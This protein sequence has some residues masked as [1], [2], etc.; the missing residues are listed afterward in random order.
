[1]PLGQYTLW[2]PC[3]YVEYE[4]PHFTRAQL[5][6]AGSLRD[7]KLDRLKALVRYVNGKVLQEAPAKLSD[8]AISKA[9]GREG[10]D[11]LTRWLCS[12]CRSMSEAQ[13]ASI[14]YDGRN[15][16]ARA[17]AD[18]WE[19]HQEHDR[20]REEQERYESIQPSGFHA[21]LIEEN[22]S[23]LLAQTIAE[24]Q[25]KNKVE[26]PAPRGTFSSSTTITI[27]VIATE[28]ANPQ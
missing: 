2:M 12:A 27:T 25:N 21:K 8:S 14:I 17:L 1:M 9:C 18:W 11:N 16:Q 23:E 26:P 22:R 10:L 13:K 19:E 4:T 28:S 24:T 3:K 6:E 5:G 7:K 15:S 20:L